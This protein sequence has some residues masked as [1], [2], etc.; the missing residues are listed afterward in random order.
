MTSAGPA[1]PGGCRVVSL[2]RSLAVLT[3][4]AA[5]MQAAIMAASTASS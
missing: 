3:M 5:M 4:G 1:V 2:G